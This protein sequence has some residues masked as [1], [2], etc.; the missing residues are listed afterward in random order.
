M[1]EKQNSSIEVLFSFSDG[2][3]RPIQLRW[4]D[5]AYDLAGVQFWYA[6]HKGAALV[7]HYTVG[8]KA[9]NFTFC[10]AMETENLT[11]KLEKAIPVTAG[12]LNLW[13]NRG[14]VGATS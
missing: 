7:H 3:T 2:Y 4:Q 5:E 13:P 11:W 14:L 12:R 8:D 9:G 6:E 10:L 1:L